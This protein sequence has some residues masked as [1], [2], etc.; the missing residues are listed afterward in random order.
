M[1]WSVLA[2]FGVAPWA[3][4]MARLLPRQCGLALALLPLGLS[5]FF[6]TRLPRIASGEV[7]TESWSWAPGLQ[8]NLSL[9][10]D[11]LSLLFALLVTGVGALVVFYAGAYL[12]DHPQLGRFYCWL[13]LFMA[14]MLGLVLAGNV[15]T[16]FIFWEL[17]S[18]TSYFLIGFDHEREKA[19]KAALMALLITGLGGAALLAGLLLLGAAAGDYEFTTLLAQGELLRDHPHYLAALLLVLAGAFTKSAQVPFHF[20]LPA[21]MEAPTPV[22]AYLHSVTMVKA[23]VYLL[24]RFHP[25][26]GGTDPWLLL[27]TGFG[28]ATLLLGAWLAL[29]ETD[30]KKIL[31][32]T[33]VSALG[34][35]VFLLGLGTPLALQ[36]AMVYLLAHALYKGALFLSAGAV[37]HAMGTRDISRLRG[38][39]RP[40]P[41][42]AV[43]ISLAAL[44]MAGIPP[45][46]GF[47]AKE[48]LYKAALIQPLA[49]AVAW[50]A[51]VLLVA[52]AALL[53]LRPFFAPAENPMP[54]K[55]Q[56]APALWLA[57]LLLALAGLLWGIFPTQIDTSLLAAASG[58]IGGTPPIPLELALWHGVDRV[59]LLSLL[60][61]ATG[62]L[63]YRLQPWLLNRLAGLPPL[64]AWGP[65]RLYELGL[66]GLFAV[67]RRQTAIIQNGYL[68]YYILTIVLF[69]IG[70]TGTTLMLKGI[71]L[72]VP[73]LTG[74]R[75]FEMTVTVMILGAAVMAVLCPSRLGAVVAMGII[76]YGVALFFIYFGA[77]D[78][79]ITQFVI[80][81]VTVILFVLC[82]RLLPP[83]LPREKGVVRWRNALV[84][85]ASGT[86]MTLLV[87][88][89]LETGGGSRLSDFFADQ[90][91][92]A[93]HGRNIVNV[94]LV[95]FRA[96]DTLGEIVVLTLAGVGVYALLH[97]RGRGGEGKSCR[98]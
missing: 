21:A 60:T 49:M 79:A 86:L 93:A 46:L 11:G 20:W 81:T 92:P 56:P 13:L 78:L 64:A 36:A 88:V 82:I 9:Y 74:A 31:A 73:A 71:A 87:L 94:I 83:Y 98:L 68:R 53:V 19:R 35:L 67:A 8:I 59:L 14:S 77:P 6:L 76:G 30:M 44:S 15:L 66:A 29:L 39:A 75:L 12:R 42:L 37:D 1:I 3:V 7:I 2:I 84:A 97:L 58:A 61:L 27:L 54:V 48:S 41:L 34:T 95:D 89:V 43:A 26:L 5:L 63:L 70:L 51:G 23:G 16:L 22:S 57:P 85:G 65:E 40:L 25:V 28:A 38:L 91:W 69:A 90:T 10:L 17:T 47:I 62:L 80:E 96:M 24:A 45:L 55:H 50:T 33:T 32:Y 72:P 4:L 52:V 18:I